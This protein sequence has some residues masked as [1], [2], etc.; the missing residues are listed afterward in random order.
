MKILKLVGLP[1][2]IFVI[3]ISCQTAIDQPDKV[4][5]QTKMDSISYIIGFDYGMGISEQQIKADPIMIYKGI[6]DALSGNHDYFS[7]SVREKIIA[8]FNETI[9]AIELE[10]F[11]KMVEENKADGKKFLQENKKMSGVV[12]LPSGLQ[13][14]IVKIGTG[15]H[16]PAKT[17]SVSIHYRA[18][19]TDRTTFDMSYDT[20]PVGIRL[21]YLIRGLSDGIQLMKKGDIYEFYISP[22]LGYGDENYF[23]MIP[24]GST[25]IYSVELIDFH[26]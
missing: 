11:K 24:A 13:Y 7:D 21:M 1:L 8:D 20:G 23:D 12:E 15:K 3:S 14:K 10:R 22:E 26:K 18:M 5:P 4:H 6:Y 2:L 25:I 17:D 19:Y 16:F 9:R